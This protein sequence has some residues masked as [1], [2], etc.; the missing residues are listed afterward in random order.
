ML[1][2]EVVVELQMNFDLAQILQISGSKVIVSWNKLNI[3][4]KM[5]KIFRIYLKIRVT[6]KTFVSTWHSIFINFKVK[7]LYHFHD[8]HPFSLMSFIIEKNVDLTIDIEHQS[9]LHNSFFYHITWIEIKQTCWTLTL[10]FDPGIQI[11]LPPADISMTST[12]M[13]ST[14]RTLQRTWEVVIFI[15]SNLKKQILK[16]DNQNQSSKL[17]SIDS[18]LT[19]FEVERR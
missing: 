19:Q 16:G 1:G 2:G 17:S 6:M 12:L 10:L 13:Q 8:F 5:R 14:R 4:L 9:K 15:T 7:F 18:L 11:L 3:R